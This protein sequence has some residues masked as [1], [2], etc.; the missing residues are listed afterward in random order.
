MYLVFC[1]N[2]D[3]YNGTLNLDQSPPINK[4]LKRTIPD[5]K[6]NTPSSPP[7]GV[8]DN[9]DINNIAFEYGC[10]GMLNTNY[11]YNYIGNCKYLYPI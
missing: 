6:V 3:K 8:S 9:P 2:S 10:S 5:K 7:M 4:H 11:G 1:N